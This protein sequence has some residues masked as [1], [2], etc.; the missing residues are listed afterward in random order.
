[1]IPQMSNL[2]PPIRW[3]GI[4]WRT[5]QLRQ[6]GDRLYT[7]LSNQNNWYPQAHCEMQWHT[8]R[9]IA[10]QP[11]YQQP[12]GAGE[13]AK[14]EE[15]AVI[16]LNSGCERKKQSSPSLETVIC[17]WIKG[18]TQRRLIAFLGLC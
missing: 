18:C 3:R 12:R 7:D 14:G 4:H 9:P 10:Q 6:P 8:P 1:M 15:R 11:T 5:D 2:R 16:D 13:N 17:P